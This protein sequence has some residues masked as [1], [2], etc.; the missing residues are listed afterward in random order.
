MVLMDFTR[1][2]L[3]SEWILLDWQRLDDINFDVVDLDDQLRIVVSRARFDYV[4]YLG[5]K[6]L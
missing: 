5:L 4:F 2:S 6:V 3:I 1:F